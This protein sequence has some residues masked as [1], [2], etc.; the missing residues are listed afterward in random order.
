VVAGD[1]TAD[2]RYLTAFVSTRSE[3]IVPVVESAE[4]DAFTDADRQALEGAPRRLG[5]CLPKR[6]RRR[7]RSAGG[8]G[9]R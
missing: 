6:S 7:L 5:A 2:P 8:H 1:V 3:E 9:R 4:R